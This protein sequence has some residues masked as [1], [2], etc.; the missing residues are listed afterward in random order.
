MQDIIDI[1]K[2]VGPAAAGV[3]TLAWLFL[4]HLSSMQETHRGT[5][6]SVV[7]RHTASAKQ[8]A[9]ECHASHEK[10]A[11][12]TSVAIQENTKV[13]GEVN[14]VSD[15]NREAT[16]ELREATGEL[17]IVIDRANRR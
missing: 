11:L 1:L 3:I 6:E 17:K 10:T 7:D 16:K 13:L 12:M 2:S 8:M 14:V 15:L 5:I 4:R 9:E